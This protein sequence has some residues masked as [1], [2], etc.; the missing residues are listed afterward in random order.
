MIEKFRAKDVSLPKPH[1]QVSSPPLSDLEQRLKLITSML[2][3]GNLKEGMKLA[4]LDDKI[5]PFSTDNYQKVLFKNPKRGKI[6]TP[7]PKKIVFSYSNSIYT[8][9]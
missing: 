2:D 1:S 7:N 9:Q 8:K 3:E 4:A 5:A 6:A